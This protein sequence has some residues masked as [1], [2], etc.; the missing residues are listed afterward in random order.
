MRRAA[1]QGSTDR[2]WL[3]TCREKARCGYWMEIRK[4]KTRP[5]WWGLKNG[6]PAI[7]LWLS[8]HHRLGR[9]SPPSALRQRER[10]RHAIRG[11]PAR[12]RQP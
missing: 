6:I 8:A 3:L 11:K 7:K 1:T 4:K 12:L 2:R 9:G 5:G 10:V